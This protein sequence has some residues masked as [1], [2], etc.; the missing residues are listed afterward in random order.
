MR[1]FY[2]VFS[3]SLAF[4]LLLWCAGCVCVTNLR[5]RHQTYVQVKMLFIWIAS[6]IFITLF[7]TIKYS[8][9]QSPSKG[10]P[11]KNTLSVL[12]KCLSFILYIYAHSVPQTHK[13]LIHISAMFAYLDNTLNEFWCSHHIPFSRF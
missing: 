10:Q 12:Q 7:M 6:K 11:F 1:C 8:L 13:H 2:A 5:Q 9:L 3:L 4:V